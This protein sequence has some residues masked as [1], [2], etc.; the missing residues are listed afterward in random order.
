MLTKVLNLVENIGEFD[1]I[2]LPISTFQKKNGCVTVTEGGIV[3]DFVKR[4]PDIPR[5]MGKVV[6]IYGGCP[7]D[8]AAFTMNS[9]TVKLFT[10]PITPVTIIA[11]E[12]DK[13]V[14]TQ[15]IG[16]F[17]KGKLVPGFLCKPRL[18]MVEFS[19]FKLAQ[20]LKWFSMKNNSLTCAIPI[21]AFGLVP[22]DT[23]D[24]KALRGILDK[25]L[26]NNFYLIMPPKSAEKPLI[27]S[28]QSTVTY[29]DED[30]DDGIVEF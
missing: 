27:S 26:D 20:I 11:Q 15:F 23:E 7:H 21:N 1:I 18:D 4:Y 22:S 5:E 13:I 9:R 3:E 8:V 28:V 2:A 24:I 25:Y 29:D 12:P 14:Q 17:K 19:A 6:E 16:R 10:F 30:E